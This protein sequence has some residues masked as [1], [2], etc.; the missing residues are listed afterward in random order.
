MG[1]WRVVRKNAKRPAER[2]FM[3]NLFLFP[4]VLML[5]IVVCLPHPEIASF[6]HILVVGLLLACLVFLWGWRQWRWGE[7]PPE[8]PP[9]AEPAVQLPRFSMTSWPGIQR[10]HL[11][12]ELLWRTP[13]H[14]SALLFLPGLLLLAL[15]R[16]LPAFGDWLLHGDAWL[17]RL[18]P[19]MLLLVV[20]ES[21]LLPL[22]LSWRMSHAMR[23][24]GPHIGFAFSDA[25]IES[26]VGDKQALIPW[27]RVT[28]AVCTPHNVCFF[29]DI[30]PVAAVPRAQLD[31]AQLTALHTLAAAKLR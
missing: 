18:L 24:L 31:A 25:G 21:L 8:A 9:P 2:L 16:L 23:R 15:G 28:S 5:A 4:M 11:S 29:R 30:M 27:E 1:Q 13:S 19:L 17:L 20:L 10:Y 7:A 12:R 14:A 22:L 6:T 26:S 3:A